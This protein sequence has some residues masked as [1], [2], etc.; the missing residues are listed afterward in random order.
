M[1]KFSAPAFMQSP[2]QHVH[3]NLRLDDDDLMI[4]VWWPDDLGMM[5]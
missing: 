1:R 4:K 2:T 5:I 3:V